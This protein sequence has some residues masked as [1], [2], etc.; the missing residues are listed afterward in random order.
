MSQK[1]LFPWLTLSITSTVQGWFILTVFCM[2]LLFACMCA[3]TLLS[4]S[5]VGLGI[6]GTLT[7]TVSC[8][9]LQPKPDTSAADNKRINQR[10]NKFLPIHLTV[11][12]ASFLGTQLNVKLLSCLLYVYTLTRRGR[13]MAEALERLDFFHAM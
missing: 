12:T 11:K 5:H 8:L 6:I 4:P 1:S 2:R 13:V 10:K 7:G 3:I 9:A